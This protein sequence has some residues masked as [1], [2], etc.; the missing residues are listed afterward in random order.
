MVRDLKKF[1]NLNSSENPY[2][3]SKPNPSEWWVYKAF[4]FS[5]YK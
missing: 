5:Y 1:M 2:P 4:T 3:N